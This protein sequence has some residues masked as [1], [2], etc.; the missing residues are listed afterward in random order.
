M[1]ESEKMKTDAELRRM[2]DNIEGGP[3]TGVERRQGQGGPF[4]LQQRPMRRGVPL[5]QAIAAEERYGTI[6]PRRKA[7]EST[8]QFGSEI[9]AEVAANFRLYARHRGLKLRSCVEL[10]LREFLNSRR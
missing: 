10:A 9:D 7:S 2:S 1:T 4:P 6:E 8:V 3:W 5:Y